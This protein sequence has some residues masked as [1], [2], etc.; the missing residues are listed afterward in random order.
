VAGGL[1]LL[2]AIAGSIAL[3][4]REQRG[5]VRRAVPVAV[6]VLAAAGAVWVAIHVAAVQPAVQYVEVPTSVEP[7]PGLA[8]N[9]A[10]VENIYPY[11]RDGRLLHDVLL[12]G[13]DG[14]P[15]DVRPG[16]PD[17][18]RRALRTTTGDALF[19]TFPIRFFEEGTKRVAKPDAAP[20]VTPPTVATPALAANRR[21]S[22]ARK[23]RR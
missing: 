20:P 7:V 23:R 2:A 17:P 13:S 3:G 1:V 6:N 8:L 12:Y 22:P 5:A 14:S 18:L 9:G 21:A 10:R 16:D 4:R 11:S 15:L 19:N